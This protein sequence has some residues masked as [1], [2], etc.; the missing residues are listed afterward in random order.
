MLSTSV[1]TGG[2]VEHRARSPDPRPWRAA[3]ASTRSAVRE[4]EA[5][6]IGADHASPSA[7]PAARAPGAAPS[8]RGA[9]PSGSCRIR[10]RRATSTASSASSPP[11]SVPRV[12]P[13]AMH[14]E[15]GDRLLRVLDLE[16]RRTRSSM[17]PGIADLAAGLAVERRVRRPRS[18]TSSPSL[19]RSTSAPSLTI[20]TI[21]RRSSCARSR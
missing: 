18:R 17:R 13:T 21:W 7:A 2:F 15:A 10:S 9:S 19:A 3:P 20:A 12:D 6:A 14:D 4:V 1:C 16:L 5:Q 8:A 11:R